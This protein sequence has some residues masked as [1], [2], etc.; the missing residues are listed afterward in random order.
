MS[1]PNRRTFGPVLALGL[2]AGALAAVA[3]NKSWAGASGAGARSFSQLSATSEAEQM[4]AAGA[5]A[6]VVLACWGVLLVTRGR[7][8]RAVAALAALAAAATLA[9]VVV[10]FSSVP[11][12]VRASFADVGIDQVDVTRTGWFW[13]AAVG[14]LLSLLT[15]LAAVRWAPYWPE[16]GTR[17]DAPGAAAA[18]TSATASDPADQTSLDL[19][20]ALDEGRDPTA[21]PAE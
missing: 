4:P 13:A 18:P 14:A 2:A 7:V 16:M 9:S 20:K 10:G 12:A 17:Y 1:H 6:L 11:S 19:W 8:R 15:T 3:G 5:F 21:G